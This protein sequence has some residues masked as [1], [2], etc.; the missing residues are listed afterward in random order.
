MPTAGSL[1][2][3]AELIAL[4]R[5]A[6]S[7][8]CGPAR[9]QERYLEFVGHTNRDR[10]RDIRAINAVRSNPLQERGRR[11]RHVAVI[12]LAPGRALRVVGMLGG[13][14]GHVVAI[15]RVIEDVARRAQRVPRPE[16]KAWMH[17]RGDPVSVRA[18]RCHAFSRQ[19]RSWDT[20]RARSRRRPQRRMAANEGWRHLPVEAS[21]R[22]MR[23]RRC[24]LEAINSPRRVDRRPAIPC[25]IHPIDVHL[26]VAAMF[27]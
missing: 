16:H 19:I 26:R 14:G 12:T 25:S 6:S 4:Q 24:L 15:G 13:V 5:R 22:R 2:L 27:Q 18:R 8:M 23:K 20:R 7:A 10:F 11:V 21:Q 9:P 17:A 1:W 3:I